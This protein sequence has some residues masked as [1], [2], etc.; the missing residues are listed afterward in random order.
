MSKILV[1]YENNSPTVHLVCKKL[2]KYEKR[3]P[4]TFRILKTSKSKHTDILWCDIVLS[5]RGFSCL[6]ASIARIA[7]KYGRKHF[8]FM[9]DDLLN[10]PPGYR[11]M[12]GRTTSLTKILEYTDLFLCSNPLIGEKYSK[13]IKSKKYVILHEY[14]QP[15]EIITHDISDNDNKVRILY[16]ANKGHIAL[17]DRY[18]KPILPHLQQ[19]YKNRIDFTFIGVHPE[20]SEFEKDIDITYIPPMAFD[21]YRDYMRSNQ[22]DIG[23]APLSDDS[24]SSKKYF[25]KFIEYSLFGIAG[26]YSNCPPYTFIVENGIN[27]LLADNSDEGW[28]SCFE[29]LIENSE[30]RNECAK[31]AQKLLRD[32]FTEENWTNDVNENIPEFRQFTA[33]DVKHVQ[34][35]WFD[36]AHYWLFRLKEYLY[37]TCVHLKEDG[38]IGTIKRVI[39]HIRDVIAF[40]KY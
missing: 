40:G 12:K 32:K 1:E 17:F 21:N 15:S 33:S 23:L 10:P 22:F 30:L 39:H 14:V 34:P 16:A 19:K 36:K 20:L 11:V 31:N 18:I 6:S 29:R 37:F 5:I 2:E 28:F 25:N 7:K 38:L 9:D 27:G 35:L 8:L 3:E 4:C 13:Y 24:F 26:I